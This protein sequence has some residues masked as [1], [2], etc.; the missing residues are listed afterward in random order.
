MEE[1]TSGTCDTIKSP[2]IVFTIANTPESVLREF[3]GLRVQLNITSPALLAELIRF[4]KL[5]P[6]PK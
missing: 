1:Q 3:R 6:T 2:N 4:Y 5:P